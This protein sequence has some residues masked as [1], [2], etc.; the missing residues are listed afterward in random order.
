M[1]IRGWVDHVSERRV[2]G[3]VHSLENPSRSER[4]T[5]IINSVDVV[6]VLACKPRQDMIDQQ[7]SFTKK[8]FDFSLKDFLERPANIV[9]IVH[10]ETRDPLGPDQ[11]YLFSNELSMWENCSDSDLHLVRQVFSREREFFKTP[12]ASSW[13]EEID[14]APILQMTLQFVNANQKLSV[15]QIEPSS[16]TF[17]KGLFDLNR[18]GRVGV[19]ERA[20]HLHEWHLNANENYA[21]TDVV[22]DL[23]DIEGAWDVVFLPMLHE[24]SGPTFLD[25]LEKSRAVLSKSGLVIFDIRVDA[26]SRYPYLLSDGERLLRVAT[27]EDA[28]TELR[29]AGLKLLKAF[30][31]SYIVGNIDSVRK[32][33]ITSRLA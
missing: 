25:I 30:D 14:Y 12:S 32:M 3:W 7:I 1:A 22:D 33:L 29:K 28:Q 17:A 4:V 21:P 13:N 9:K 5:V 18:L 11:Y 19:V 24:R 16:A 23:N 2:R 8:G 15:L 6:S 26:N 27:L 10:S 31:F 20:S